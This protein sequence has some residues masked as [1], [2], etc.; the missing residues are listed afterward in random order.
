MTYDIKFY[1][2]FINESSLIEYFNID[3]IYF[4]IIEFIMIIS[5]ITLGLCNNYRSQK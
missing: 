1:R 5:L 3:I 2:Y 4:L